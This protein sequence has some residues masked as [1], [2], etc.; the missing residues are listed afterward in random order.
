[1]TT[2]YLFDSPFDDSGKHLLI[3]REKNVEGFL[4]ELLNVLPY[5]RY[6]NV[7]WERQGQTFRCPVRADELRRYNYMAYQNESRIEFAYIIDYQYVNN[8][9][10]YVNIA[11]DYWATYIDKFTFHPSPIV[12][13]HPASD[14][15]FA[16]FYPE[17]TQ[18]DRWEIAR[19]EYGYSKDDDDSVYLMTANNTDTYENRSS[20]FYAA[21]ANFAMGDYGQIS[22]FFSVV[23]VNPCECGG[24]IQSNTS[25]LS[26]SQALEVVKRYAKCGRQEDVIGAYH[27]PKFFAAD[28]SGENLDKIDNRTGTIELVQTFLEKPLWNK[29]YTSPQFNKLTVNCGGNAKEYDFRYFDESA[30]LA[31]KFSFKW[32]ANQSQLGGII[33]T[34]Q[35]YGNGT[36]GDYSLASSTWDSVQLSTTQLN[37]SGVI[38][39]IGNFGVATIG[40]VISLD[41]KGELQ[42]AENLGSKYEESD[43]TIGNPTGTIAMYNALFPMISIAWYYPSLQDIKKLNN[44]FCMYGYNYNGSLAD[45]VIDSLPIVNYVHTSGAIITAENAPQ[46]AIAYMVNRLDSGAFF[47]H[48]I[49][50]YKRTDKILENHFPERD[51]E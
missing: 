8:K 34:P 26:R 15:L 14:G 40:N 36:N 39:D 45:I 18:V 10:T 12:R 27:V 25:K 44:Y 4:R 50:N 20:D 3:P 32:A 38:R 13:Q 37:S 46:N 6:D 16:N 9:L 51:G 33:I 43:L 41:I 17:P 30:L 28:V 11:I 42:S 49:E 29:L 24:I 31:K 21:I 7:T 35:Q 19:T 22:N 5:K 48:G 23:S 1:M 2:V 47:W